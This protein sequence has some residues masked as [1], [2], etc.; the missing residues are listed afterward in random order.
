MVRLIDGASIVVD[1]SADL[2]RELAQLHVRLR[3]VAAP[4]RGHRA[5]CL[6]EDYAAARATGYVETFFASS[7]TVFVRDPRWDKWGGRVVADAI[8]FPLP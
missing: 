1:A 8:R 6:G 2:S 7:S 5:R 4:K 3:G